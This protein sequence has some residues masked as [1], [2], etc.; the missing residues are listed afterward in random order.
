M[1]MPLIDR[2]VRVSNALLTFVREDETIRCLRDHIVVEPL[3]IDHGTMMQLVY[4]GEPVRGK[5]LAVGPGHFQKRYDGPKGKRTKTWDSKHF[6]PC[7]IKPGDVVDLGGLE[8]NGYLFTRVLWGGKDVIIST[9]EADVAIA[10]DAK[11]GES[12]PLHDRVIVRRLERETVSRGGIEIVDTEREPYL[13][14]EIIAVGP[15]KLLESGAVIPLDVKIGDRIWFSLATQV[16]I[17]GE[18]L[19][20]MREEDIVAVLEESPL[21]LIAENSEETWT[22]RRVER[23]EMLSDD[24]IGMVIRAK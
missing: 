5:V 11:T 6:T 22:Y 23:H 17:G 20:V 15:G 13:R 2:G 24:L 14:G 4:R 10:F 3:D 7:D 8:L 9:R 19:L 12:R 21:W 1:N 16:Q 18:E